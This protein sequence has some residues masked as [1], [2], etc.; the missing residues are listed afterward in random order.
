MSTKHIILPNTESTYVTDTYNTI[1][2]EFNTRFSVW[3]NVA[4][5]INSFLSHV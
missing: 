5:F 4:K 1:A 2:N 3:S